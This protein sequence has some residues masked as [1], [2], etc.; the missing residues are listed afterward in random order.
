MNTVWWQLQHQSRQVGYRQLTKTK[1]LEANCERSE[2]TDRELLCSISGCR[3]K[4]FAFLN[5]FSPKPTTPSSGFYEYIHA[6][7]F[8]KMI[9]LLRTQLNSHLLPWLRDGTICEEKRLDQFCI[10]RNEISRWDVKICA[11]AF[12]LRKKYP[13]HKSA[14]ISGNKSVIIPTDWWSKEGKSFRMRRWF[15][16]NA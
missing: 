16:K 8:V 7:D 12:S 15:I 6:L 14:T 1:V 9:R 13:F 3:G 11:I 10:L 4:L 2:P 5:T